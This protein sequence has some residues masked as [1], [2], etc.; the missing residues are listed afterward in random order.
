MTT[1]FAY[2]IEAM[3]LLG[4]FSRPQSNR[5]LTDNHGV[6]NGKGS[7]ID[8]R[9]ANSRTRYPDEAY[10]T[11]HSNSRRR[12]LFYTKKQNRTTTSTKITANCTSALHAS[13]SSTK[14]NENA[15]FKPCKP[16]ARLTADR[17]APPAPTAAPPPIAPGA[18]QPGPAGAS[19]CR[20]SA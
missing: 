13:S 1:E 20:R 15:S 12:E 4:A 11:T 14:D 5:K 2:E 7:I 19:F 8:N 10:N 18:W 16:N 9:S 17:A 6:T 3:V